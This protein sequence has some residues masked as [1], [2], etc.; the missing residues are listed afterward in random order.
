[1]PFNSISFIIFFALLTGAYFFV[2]A[3]KKLVVLLVGSW[4]FFSYANA[5][6]LLNLLL[7]TVIAYFFATKIKKAENSKPFLIA[8]VFLIFLQLIFAKYTLAFANQLSVNISSQDKFFNFF[9]LPIGISFYSLQA[10]GLLVDI[11]SKKYQDELRFK[12]VSLFLSFFPQSVSGPIHRANELLPQFTFQNK[13]EVSNIVIGIKTMVWGYFCKLI[14]ADKISLLT[15]PIFNT[16]FEQDG[17]SLLIAS[18]LFSIQIYFDFWGYS[19]IAIGAGRILGFS[20]NINFNAPYSVASFKE[21]WH[22]WHITLSKWMRDYVY[23]PLG[24]RNQ[25]KYILFCFTIL[26]TFLVSG[27]WHGITFNFI[28]WGTAHAFLYL[29]EDF[30]SRITSTISF[31]QKTFFKTRFIQLFKLLIFFVLISLTWLIFRTDNF[32]ELKEILGRII[33]IADWSLINISKNYLTAT[34]VTYLLIILIAF[35]FSRTTFIKEKIDLVPTTA[36]ETITDSVF[37]CFCITTIILLG[38][39]GSQEFLYF[40]F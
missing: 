14:I 33:S 40:R 31:F 24:G 11:R 10:I 36:P 15:A 23:I 16:Y 13:F 28:L 4:L 1:M 32:S 2:D 19:L 22:R 35:F 6:N 38:D 30:I 34:N 20:I 18:L 8:G 26:I 37:L 3:K 17:L 39:I 25:K 12:D 21:F 29:S 9:I 7:T 5:F 27:F